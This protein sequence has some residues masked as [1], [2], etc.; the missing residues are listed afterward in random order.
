MHITI[1]Y[2]TR[3]EFLKVKCLIDKLRIKNIN[4]NV[5]RINQH[6]NL[7]EDD[8]YY[9]SCINIKEHT[10]NRINNIG[11]SILSELPAYLVESNTSHLLAQ[12]DT[13]SCFYSI[14][15]AFQLHIT[16]IH[17][18][19]GMRTYNL[20]NP[21]PEEG[22]REMI[23][24]ITNI[25]LCPSEYEAN[26]LRKEC[27]PHN[28]IHIIGN[29]IIDLVKSYNIPITI[30]NKIII[31]LHRRE[32]WN[33][34]KDYIKC[35]IKLCQKYNKYQF[36]FFTHLNPALNLI[37][38]NTISSLGNNI[39]NLK[40][41]NAI[42]HIELIK[43]ISEAQCIITDSGG[44]QEEANFLGKHIYIVRKITERHAIPYTKRTYID[45]ESFDNILLP[46]IQKEQG[47]EYGN[48]NSSDELINIIMK[49][50]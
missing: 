47:Y 34:Y 10:N 6:I 13:A 3:P 21:F 22:F 9:S 45:I 1:I 14:L 31:T 49:Y 30:T 41:M 29:T 35:I 18:E 17:L 28:N 33:D 46:H 11:I 43:H 7:E 24:R 16:T 8:G 4:H 48:G 20:D 15:C 40:I 42:K 39:Y 25:H 26:I 37:I 38:N 50:S 44:L 19:A 32:N 27:V 12:G 5:I 2:G 23:S 36:I